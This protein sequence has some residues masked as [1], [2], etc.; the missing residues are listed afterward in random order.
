MD[1]AIGV[2]FRDVVEIDQGDAA[3]GTACQR[4]RDPRTDAAD[5][6]NGDT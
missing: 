2:G 4:F 3:D 6:D 5:A 1:L